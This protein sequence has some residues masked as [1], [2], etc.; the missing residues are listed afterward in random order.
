MDTSDIEQTIWPR[1][2]A[3][4]ERLWSPRNI[5]STDEGEGFWVQ[6]RPICVM[7][8]WWWLWLVA[9]PPSFCFLPCS[10]SHSPPALLR[11]PLPSQP[12][13]CGRGALGQRCR[14]R[15]SVWPRR[16]LRSVEDSIR[17]CGAPWRP[18]TGRAW[19]KVS[20]PSAWPTLHV[21]DTAGHPLLVIYRRGPPWAMDFDFRK[22]EDQSSKEVDSHRKSSQVIRHTIPGKASVNDVI[23]LTGFP[24]SPLLCSRS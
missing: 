19:H 12:P 16:L 20:P 23:D 13:R 1:L 6:Q 14:P 24:L 10:L 17:H 7:S 5:N 3:I 9:H 8:V 4:A 2:G 21:N 15:G 11:I 22:P 18:C